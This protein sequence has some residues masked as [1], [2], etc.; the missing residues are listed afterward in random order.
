MLKRLG[1]DEASSFGFL[2]T[3]HLTSY[4]WCSVEGRRENIHLGSI[5]LGAKVRTRYSISNS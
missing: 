3:G 2:L 1:Q 4:C 5:S